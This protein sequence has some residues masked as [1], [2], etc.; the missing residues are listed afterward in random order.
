V[1]RTRQIII[2]LFLFLTLLAVGCLGY[3]VI[4]DWPF[5]DAIYMTIITLA[6]VGYGEVHDFKFGTRS[7]TE[8]APRFTA[9]KPP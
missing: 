6:T 4:E 7:W 8:S 5:M 2:S 9:A 3:M 1:N